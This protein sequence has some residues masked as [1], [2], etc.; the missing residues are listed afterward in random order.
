MR[1]YIYRVD[2]KDR[3]I[4]RRKKTVDFITIRII[5]YFYLVL[6]YRHFRRMAKK[7]KKQ[8][9]FFG[10]NYILLL[11]GRIVC[12]IYRTSFIANMFEAINIVNLGLV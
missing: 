6:N 10:Y 4:K 5:K 1:R 2:E 3:F 9:G 11:E 8:D 12:I 7:A